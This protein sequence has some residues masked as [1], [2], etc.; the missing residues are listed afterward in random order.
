M[1]MFGQ[2]N[3]WY[4]NNPEPDLTK[5][6]KRKMLI[7]PILMVFIVLFIGVPVV[8]LAID[9]WFF[10][11]NSIALVAVTVVLM[12]FNKYCEC[13]K[14]SNL[15]K[16]LYLL[17]SLWLTSLIIW[18]TYSVKAGCYLDDPIIKTGYFD[19]IS[20]VLIACNP[21]SWVLVLF[22]I[23]LACLILFGLVGFVLSLL[24]SI[25]CCNADF[26]QAYLLGFALF[27]G[28]GC[29]DC[30]DKIIN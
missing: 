20:G 15:S 4:S 13:F 11:Y 24:V 6:I 16:S 10:L 30:F 29:F 1:I 8:V 17:T 7:T 18:A 27:C 28:G 2:A 19:I 26:I 12:V 22:V 14:F 25:F 23:S 5:D 21:I 3:A 9:E